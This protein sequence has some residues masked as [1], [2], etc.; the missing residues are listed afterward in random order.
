MKGAIWIRL[1]ALYLIIGV[2]VGLFMSYTLDL[3]WDSAHAH[4]NL[5]GFASTA[6]FGVIY[7]VYPKAAVNSTGKVHFWLHNLGIPIFLISAFL[8]QVD[9]LLDA[10]HILTYIGGGAFFLGTLF[11]AYNAFQYINDSSTK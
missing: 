7:S 1:A 11:F 3:Q 6:L 5:V 10:A 4:V 2:L 8:V 9:N